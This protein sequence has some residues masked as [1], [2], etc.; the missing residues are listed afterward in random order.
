MGVGFDECFRYEYPRV[1]SNLLI[2]HHRTAVAERA[3]HERLRQAPASAV[4]CEPGDD[5]E[6]LVGPLPSR[7]RVIVTLYY[8][9]DRSVDDIASML[10]IAPGTVKSAL[11]KARA[12]MLEALSEEGGDGRSN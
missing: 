11:G 12:R 10:D 6:W 7:Q 4:L 9:E 3:A 5:W 2:D 1:M 8:A